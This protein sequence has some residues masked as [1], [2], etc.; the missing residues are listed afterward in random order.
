MNGAST[1]KLTPLPCTPPLLVT[2][3]GPLLA[4]LGTIAVMLVPD[5]VEIVAPAP[6]KLTVPAV[7]PKELPEMLTEAPG[8]PLAGLSKRISGAFS[9][10]DV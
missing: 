3:T 6:L 10:P 7:L 2:T 8:S 5:H 1:V 9:T 4:P